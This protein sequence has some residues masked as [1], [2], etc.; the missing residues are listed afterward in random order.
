MTLS[1]LLFFIFQQLKITSYNIYY[2][3]KIVP[4]YL[5]GTNK[6]GDLWNY[7]LTEA[8]KLIINFQINFI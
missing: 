4:F 8:T 7:L 3:E 6:G 5:K 1:R 2:T